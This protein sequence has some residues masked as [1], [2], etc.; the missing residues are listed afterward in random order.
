ML[1]KN[2]TGGLKKCFVLFE[3]NS[4]FRLFSNKEEVAVVYFRSGYAPEHYTSEK[5]MKIILRHNFK[6]LTG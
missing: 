6:I 3:L 4:F 1:M 2:K 5:V